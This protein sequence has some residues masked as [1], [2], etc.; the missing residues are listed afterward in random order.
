MPGVK[1]LVRAVYQI[2]FPVGVLLF[3]QWYQSGPAPAAG[4]VYIPGKLYHY[5]G[6]ELARLYKITRSP[7][8]GATPALA[9]DLYN[10]VTASYRF[11]H[12]AGIFHGFSQRLF[13]VGITPSLYRFNGVVSM[14]KISSA[15]KHRIHCF[16]VIQLIIIHTGSNI[17]IHFLLQVCLA[18]LPLIF[19]NITHGDNIKIQFFV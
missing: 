3:Q 13:R 4:L 19:P 12:S 15:Y 6:S 8:V 16:Y 17:M 7:V 2:T 1:C 14:L 11:K 10:S 5:N 18:I 9:A